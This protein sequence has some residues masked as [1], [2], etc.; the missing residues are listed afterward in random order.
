[1]ADQPAKRHKLLSHPAWTGWAGITAI[2]GAFIALFAWL[3]PLATAETPADPP[4]SAP[5]PSQSTPPSPGGSSTPSPSPS[6]SS[7]PSAT[8]AASPDSLYHLT[9]S[10]KP[11]RASW[12]S[13]YTW[14]DL[15]VPRVTDDNDI[16]D[17]EYANCGY[18]GDLNGGGESFGEGPKSEPKTAEECVDFAQTQGIERVL[19]RN[20]RLS[21][22][23][24]SV[25]SE[26]NVAWLRLVRMSGDRDQ[27][28][29]HFEMTLWKQGG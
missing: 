21:M 23:F 6:S 26:G 25:T 29:L 22:T 9:F 18:G 12:P 2:I 28:D 3:F 7:F 10:R 4:H 27:P 13:C 15:D 19:V 14:V 5:P 16:D 24:C 1:M 11:L 8:P 20:L 17:L